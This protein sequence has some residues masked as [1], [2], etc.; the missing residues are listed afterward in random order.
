MQSYRDGLLPSSRSRSVHARASRPAERASSVD[1]AEAADHE[2]DVR[3]ARER[4]GLE[5]ALHDQRLDVLID[6]E[7]DDARELLA[8]VELLPELALVLQD[9]EE[10]V[11][12]LQAVG[13]FDGARVAGRGAVDEDLLPVMATIGASIMSIA[14]SAFGSLTFLSIG[15]SPDAE[16]LASRKT[17]MQSRKS[18]NWISGM[19][20]IRRDCRPCRRPSSHEP[21]RHVVHQPAPGRCDR[22]VKRLRAFRPWLPQLTAKV[23]LKAGPSRPCRRR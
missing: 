4:R 18:M 2:A 1:S 3:V 21:E 10:L 16:K 23:T 20:V 22:L 8:R 9:V 6:L 14:F 7:D 19:L 13:L 17:T 11:D 12:A 15:I 5:D